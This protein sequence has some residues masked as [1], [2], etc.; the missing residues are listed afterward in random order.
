MAT[1][2]RKETG[3]RTEEEHLRSGLVGWVL[4]L[5]LMAVSVACLSLLVAS[6]LAFRHLGCKM[7]EDAL[8]SAL[9]HARITAEQIE[10][11]SLEEGGNAAER[12][13]AN[14]GNL[15]SELHDLAKA[16]PAVLYGMVFSPEGEILI[17]TDEEHE[18]RDVAGAG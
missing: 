9:R 4:G 10:R 15:R 17:H 16:D 8:G 18:L 1:D 12:L 7:A 13:R 11:M 2:E 3:I 14:A 5:G 6:H